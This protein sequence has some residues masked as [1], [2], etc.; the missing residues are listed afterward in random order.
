[1][2]HI[3]DFNIFASTVHKTP[4]VKTNEYSKINSCP[5]LIVINSEDSHA[6]FYPQPFIYVTFETTKGLSFKM[7]AQFPNKASEKRVKVPYSVKPRVV[8]GAY[9]NVHVKTYL[10]KAEKD[11]KEI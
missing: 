5:S 2:A 11:P 9:D 3:R 7:K 10:E 1:M 8:E 6:H 4:S